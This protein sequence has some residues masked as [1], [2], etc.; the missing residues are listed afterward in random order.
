MARVGFAGTSEWAAEALERLAGAPDVEI[1]LALTQPDR[2]AG[3]GRRASRPP[4]AVAAER[5]GIAVAQPQAPAEALEALL[6]AGCRAMALVAY[7]ALVPRALLAALPWLNL[8]P[9][10]LP[11]WRGAAP[12]E[13]AL[14]AGER[15]LG[16][17]VML[18]VERLDA[19]PLAELLPFAVGDDEDAGDVYERALRLGLPPLARALVAAADGR[20]ATVPQVGEPTYAAKLEPRDRVLDPRGAVRDVRDRVRALSPHVGARLALGGEPF[21][22]WRVRPQAAADVAPGTLAVVADTLVLGCADGALELCELQPP[23]RRRMRADEWLRGL[24]G[25]LPAPDP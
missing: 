6:A 14:M 18:L 16:V 3:R 21:T 8:H 24:R 10:L 1:A 9:S 23:G 20:L 5:L 15:E 11:R 17:A 2:P 4:V 13:R 19:G 22:I 25:G 7:G 12:I